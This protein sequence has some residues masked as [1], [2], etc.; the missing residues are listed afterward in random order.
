MHARQAMLTEGVQ[1]EHQ[2][3]ATISAERASN[4]TTQPSTVVP[5]L[6]T[7]GASTIKTRGGPTIKAQHHACLTRR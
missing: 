2:D 1:V 4:L 5:I 3:T 6:Q 7:C